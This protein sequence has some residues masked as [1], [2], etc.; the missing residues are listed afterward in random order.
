MTAI[1]P[2]PIRAP[3]DEVVDGLRAMR[4]AA[5]QPSYAELALRIARLRA[6]RGMSEGQA[7]VARTTVY[8][9]FRAGRRRLDLDLVLDIVRALG[10]T[11]DEVIDWRERCLAAQRRVL[12]PE[13]PATDPD[14]TP[15]APVAAPDPTP[16]PGPEPVPPVIRTARFIVLVLLACVG[17]NLLGRVIVDALHVSIYL[18]MSGTAVASVLLGPWWGALVGVLTNGIGVLTSGFASLPFALVNVAGALVWGYGYHRFGMGRTLL[19]F[20]ALSVIAGVVCTLVATPILLLMFGGFTA[21]VSSEVA[22]AVLGVVPSL[23]VAVFTSNLLLSVIDKVISGSV[24]L[25][26]RES[27]AGRRPDA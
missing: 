8:D 2:Q 17:L 16:E 22:Q 21:H 10:G 25:V 26:A 5:G 24:A 6:E 23:P 12:E 13:E 18:D 1:D 4:L 11:Q 9:A 15:A 7:R 3:L 27:L 14:P 19:R 20:F